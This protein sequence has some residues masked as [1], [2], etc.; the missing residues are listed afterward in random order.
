M[1]F[2]LLTRQSQ[3]REDYVYVVCEVITFTC[4]KQKKML[5]EVPGAIKVHSCYLTQWKLE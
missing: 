3:E 1:A 5:S 4:M 2:A